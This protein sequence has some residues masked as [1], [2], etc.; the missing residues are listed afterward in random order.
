M[1]KTVFIFRR[2]PDGHNNIQDS[3]NHFLNPNLAKS[4]LSITSALIGESFCN[5]AQNM[6]M[7]CKIV[8]WYNGD[9]D[10]DD[11]IDNNDDDD[12]NNK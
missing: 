5:F 6:A 7:S 3:T 9:D 11:D 10:D 2:G 8:K 12:N 4:G 1:G